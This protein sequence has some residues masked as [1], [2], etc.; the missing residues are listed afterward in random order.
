MRL[1]RPARLLQ[2]QVER[3]SDCGV[4]AVS[5]VI[6]RWLL[7]QTMGLSTAGRIAEL[8]VEPLDENRPPLEAVARVIRCPGGVP[9]RTRALTDRRAG[10]TDDSVAF[11]IGV[12]FGNIRV[13][14]SVAVP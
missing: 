7:L 5:G 8:P 13:C 10:R 12:G 2:V 14:S 4:K 1:N 11:P 3:V 9:K 6:A